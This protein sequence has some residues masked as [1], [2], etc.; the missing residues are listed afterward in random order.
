MR[1]GDAAAVA[2]AFAAAGDMDRQGDVHDLPSAE[3]YVDW[4][5][6][7]HRKATAVTDAT[8]RMIGLVGITIDPANRSGWFFSWLHAAYRGQGLMARAAGFVHEGTERGKFLIAGRRVDV[9]TYGR[10]RSDPPRR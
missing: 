10:L 4:L 6:Q 2:E 5:R 9:L 1:E 7:E 8:D 3:R